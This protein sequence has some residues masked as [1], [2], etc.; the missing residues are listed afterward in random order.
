M[1]PGNTISWTKR[2]TKQWLVLPLKDRQTV[3]SAVRALENWPKCTNVVALTGRDEYR[4]R[5]GRFR[6]I[7]SVDT[8]QR[9][10]VVRIEE[11]RKRDEQTY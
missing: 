2:A 11:V 7:F 5:V 1:S 8:L 10:I 3:A 6:V 4:L 9:P